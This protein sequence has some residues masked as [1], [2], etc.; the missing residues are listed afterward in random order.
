[1][2]FIQYGRIVK[3]LPEINSSFYTSFPLQG[4]SFLVFR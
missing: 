3:V 1:M 2:F 4:H